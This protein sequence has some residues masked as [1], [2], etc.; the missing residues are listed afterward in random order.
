MVPRSGRLKVKLQQGVRVWYA[1]R[2][3]QPGTILMGDTRD[4][5]LALLNT[6]RV[7]LLAWTSLSAVLI[8]KRPTTRRSRSA[9]VAPPPR[10]SINDYN[11]RT[12]GVVRV[13]TV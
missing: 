10:V 6:A 11:A 13:L 5:M 12:C 7:S 2:H 4:I 3:A 8:G 1:S 9:T